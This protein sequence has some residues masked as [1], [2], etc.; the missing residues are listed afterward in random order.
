MI[1]Q[2]LSPEARASIGKTIDEVMDAEKRKKSAY[3]ERIKET[4][5]MYQSHATLGKLTHVLIHEGRKH[6]KDIKETVPRMVRWA[7]KL[8]K[9]P[10]SELEEKLNDRGHQVEN[11]TKSLSH[12]FKKIEPLAR[13]RRSSNKVI[14]LRK[15]IESSLDIF[16]SEF[17]A[18][19]IE[20]IIDST[21]DCLIN[22][23]EMD[24]HTIFANLIEN[25]V[26][27][28]Q[29]ESNEK[30]F[31]K[32]E[33]TDEEGIISVLYSDSGPGFQG[34]DLSMMFEPGYSNKPDGTGLGL[35]LAG[36]AAYRNDIA[37]QAVKVESGAEFSMIF[38]EVNK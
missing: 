18:N 7:K 5:A 9:D 20:I 17:E 33:M 38:K 24:I 11:S 19:N 10:D 34:S 22:A 26:Y 14:S 3:S 30:N 29:L 23:N 37:I 31:I 32:I 4:I 8:S 1:K 36:D 27:W 28:I 15:A 2:K 6:I 12:L 21:N 13:T 16:S 25:S 35:A